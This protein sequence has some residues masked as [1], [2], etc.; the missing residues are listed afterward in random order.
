[1]EH[2]PNLPDPSLWRRI[3]GFLLKGVQEYGRAWAMVMAAPEYYDMSGMQGS[4]PGGSATSHTPPASS[5]EVIGSADAHPP[6]VGE[7][8]VYMDYKR[9]NK[10]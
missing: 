9:R 2:Y 3:G 4:L 7:L 6:V 8:T 10:L 1:M 5:E